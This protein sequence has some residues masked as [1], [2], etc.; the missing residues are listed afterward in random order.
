MSTEKL[1]KLPL[2]LL[3]DFFVD[4]EQSGMSKNSVA[5]Y[6][7]DLKQYYAFLRTHY[8]HLEQWEHI[9][10][11][12]ISHYLENLLQE[13]LT[14][15]TIS[16]KQSA[17]RKFYKFLKTHEKIA[18]NPMEGII[19]PKYRKDLPEILSVDEMEKIINTP[20][21][22]TIKGIQNRAILEVLYATGM[23]VSELCELKLSQLHL[24]VGSINIIGKGNKER[25]SL[26]GDNALESLENYFQYVRHRYIQDDDSTVF[27]SRRGKPFTRQGIWKMIKEVVQEA[28]VTK[29]VTPH[30]FRHCAAT[31]LLSNGMDLKYIQELLGHEQLVTTQIY[32]KVNTRKNHEDYR[33]AHPHA[34]KNRG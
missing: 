12:H 8:N 27:L 30:T 21:V 18:L 6:K 1:F 33:M 5:S 13:N 28:G 34:K 14:V 22:T 32:T 16:R 24:E 26:L 11:E 20:D 9:Q 29:E 2:T 7:M 25:V 23:R 15:K 17:L 4:L 3:V 31:H 10:S 19:Y